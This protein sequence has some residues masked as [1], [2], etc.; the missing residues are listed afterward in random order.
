MRR[1]KT[2]IS[3]HSQ[4]CS[5]ERRLEKDESL[6]QQYADTINVDLQNGYVRKLEERELAAMKN[7]RQWYV[8]HHPVINPHRPEKVRRV[9]NAAAK[10]KGESPTDKHVTGP[11]LLKNL[12]G[13]IFRFR[14]HQ[15]ALTA[16]IKAMFL[17]VKV[18]PEECRV[19]RFLWRSKPE[20]KIGVYGYTRHVFAAKSSPTCANYPLLQAGVDNQVDHPIAAEAIKRNFYMD[21]YAKSVATLEAI[22]VYKDVRTNLKLCGFNLLKWICNHD[23]LTKNIPEGDRS[24][25][26]NK[27][28]EAEPHAS[29]LL[30]MQ[31]NVDDTLEI[32]R[33]VDKE[34]ARSCK[35][36][37]RAVL[38]FVASV[39]DPLGLF[40]PFTM[41]M[42]ILL[43]TIWAKSGQQ[44]DDKIEVEDKQKYLEWVRELA[45]LKNMP[46][47]RRY[48][49]RSYKKID[50]QIFSDASLESMCI[51]AYVRAADE[52]GVEL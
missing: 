50:L 34:V 45:E 44:W 47:K 37:Q 48:F 20:D 49:E 23:L 9:C 28:F 19:L 15:I 1:F 4:F 13:I 22:H 41:R 46:L 11:D 3:R 21:D 16:D 33:G 42:R 8:P 25:A 17:Q 36:M 6:K 51:V 18:P 12:V 27:T 5:L 43:K 7:G 39:F 38:S 24:E 14:E 2:I 10:Y 26:K 32:C 35:I 31:W 30:G 40:A 29:S 52:D